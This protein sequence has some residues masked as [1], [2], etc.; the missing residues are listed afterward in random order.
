MFI[1]NFENINRND[2]PEAG[3]KGAFL[4]ELTRLGIEVPPGFVILTSAYDHFVKYNGLSVLIRE[5]FSALKN[6]RKSVT[7]VSDELT[8][9][10]NRGEIPHDLTNE[11]REHYS[12]LGAGLVAVRSSATAED[13]PEHSWAGQLESFLNVTPDTLLASV[14]QCWASLFTQ[15]AIT[16]SMNENE[17]DVLIRVAVVVQEMVNPEISGIAFSVNPVSENFNELVI[18]A[19]YGLGEAIVQGEITPDHYCIDKRSFDFI[20]KMPSHQEH[21]IFRLE[22]GRNGWKMI[23]P[24]KAGKQKLNDAELKKLARMV[25]DIENLAGF[26]CDIEWTYHDLRF[27]FVQCRPIT[28]LS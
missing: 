23:D 26:P 27:S 6:G 13:N 17:A 8:S 11:I 16:Y 4:G 15:R 10:F 21:G 18:E 1:K 3:G 12:L 20:E 28:T 24:E 14:K 9:L 19:A 22:N 7:E 2:V 25:M 5:N